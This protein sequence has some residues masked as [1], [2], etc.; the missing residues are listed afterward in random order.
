MIT[1][2]ELLAELRANANETYRAFHKKLLKNDAVNVIGVKTPVIRR[3]AKELRGD[4][5]DVLTFPDEYYEVKF[6][7][8]ALVGALPFEEF[9]ARL[10]ETVE[11]FDNWATCDC[12]TAPCIKRHKEE[13]LPYIEKYFS[14]GR[15]FVKRYA[16]VALLHDYVEEKYLPVIRSYLLRCKDEKYYVMMAAAWLLAEVLVKHYAAGVALLK[17]GEL[18]IEVRNKGIRKACESFRLTN[19]QKAELKTLKVSPKF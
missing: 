5:R 2:E 7:K 6:I 10:D 1:Y 4:W 14:D 18:D 3:I 12:F 16:L 19:E 17:E 11:L 15:E 13:F 9:I 8:C